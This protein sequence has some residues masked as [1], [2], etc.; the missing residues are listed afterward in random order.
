M[1]AQGRTC[2]CGTQCRAPLTLGVNHTPVSQNGAAACHPPVSINDRE[3][4]EKREYGPFWWFLDGIIREEG[5]NPSGQSGENTIRRA[6]QP[7]W[8]RRRGMEYV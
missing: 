6:R 5:A 8:L 1:K 7:A 4:R 3:K 2:R